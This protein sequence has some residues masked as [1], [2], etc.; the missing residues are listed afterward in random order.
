MKFVFGKNIIQ[1]KNIHRSL[2]K[3]HLQIV[4]SWK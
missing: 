2:I 4:G 1:A 3:V